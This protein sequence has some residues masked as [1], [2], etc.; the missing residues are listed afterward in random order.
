MV[1]RRTTMLGNAELSR[2]E[3]RLDLQAYNR[4]S[5]NGFQ[6]STGSTQPY[7]TLPESSS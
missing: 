2:M 1:Q 4:I 5:Q 3:L 7:D 6:H